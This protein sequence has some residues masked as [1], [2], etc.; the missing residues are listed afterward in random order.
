MIYSS[1]KIIN[2]VQ[3][4]QGNDESLPIDINMQESMSAAQNVQLCQVRSHEIVSPSEHCGS[5][6]AK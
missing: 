2:N 5:H 6:F 3:E 4:F 1:V